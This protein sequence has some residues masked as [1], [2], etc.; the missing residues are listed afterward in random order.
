[1]YKIS[2][3][4]KKLRLKLSCSA[5]IICYLLTPLPLLAK[6][7]EAKADDVASCKLFDTI[8]ASSGYGKKFNWQSVAKETALQQAQ[9]LGASH[10]V[11][12]RFNPIGAFN[13]IAIAKLY[14]CD[15]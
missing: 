14:K 15:T 8:E 12:D 4:Q 11:W 3:K 9:Q 7:Q 10:L 5:I 13:G 6:T 2:V 1:M